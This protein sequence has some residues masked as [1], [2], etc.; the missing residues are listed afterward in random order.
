MKRLNIT[1]SD[2]AHLCKA[3]LFLLL[4]ALSA[5]AMSLVS[6]ESLDDSIG[7]D[8]YGGGREP[9]GIKLLSE[10]PVPASGVPGDTVVFKA[11]GLSKWCNPASG[12]YDFTMYM[13]EEPAEIITATDTTLTVRV[14][15]ELSTGITYLVLQN[16]VFYGPTFTVNGNLS[17]DKEFGL[18]KDQTQFSGAIYDAVESKQK[19]QGNT[20]YLVGDINYMIDKGNLCRG[21]ALLNSNGNLT[22]STNNYFKSVR[23]TIISALD[24]N[25]AYLRS[26]S[27]THDNR[28]MVS[29][30]FSN[31][32]SAF[33][34]DQKKYLKNT[35]YL[36]TNNMTML[37]ANA[38]VDTVQSVFSEGYTGSKYIPLPVPSFNGGFKQEVLRSFVTKAEKASDQ[39]VIAVGNFNQYTTTDYQTSYY[40]SDEKLTTV[41]GVCRMNLDGSLD[42]SYR[43][44][45]S[46]PGANGSIT[47]AYLDE[48]NGVVLIGNFTAFDGKAAN[49]VVRL[50]AD[51]NVDDAYMS[52]IRN[53]FNGTIT[54]VRY[55][56]D[57]HSAIFVGRFTA[58]GNHHTQYIAKV[59]KDGVI[60]EGFKVE[61]FE[62]G[63]PT[64]GC[65][66]SRQLPKVI[67]AGTFTTFKG[68]HRRGFLVLDMDGK[69]TQK[70][71]VPGAFEG[72]IY[73]VRETE[74]SLGEYGLLLLGDFTKFNGETVNNAVMLQADFQ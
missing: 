21:I 63:V 26:V 23:G 9:L 16:Q 11:E 36:Y 14:P 72:E 5:L 13:G 31:F 51:G 33:T 6:C 3:N 68:V 38:L 34:N 39:K 17:V 74:T 61:G 58:V 55:N 66:V 15:Q 65:I 42:T 30:V 47:D 46:H 62:G 67:V 1:L 50:D 73:Q 22:T 28:M 40:S 69:V 44:A 29:G 54:K 64:F 56:E 57:T 4:M 70:F 25:K 43:P 45:A 35:T 19:G 49:G 10:A 20:F 37:A 52:H 18:Y 24:V 32:Y 8:P 48:D 2:I 53:G 27:L 41:S 60:D 12:R 7:T 71:N 59:G